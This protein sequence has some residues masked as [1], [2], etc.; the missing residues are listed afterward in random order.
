[1]Y[2]CI[3]IYIHAPETG[4]RLHGSA[5]TPQDALQ[6]LRP[7]CRGVKEDQDPRDSNTP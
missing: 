6:A 5:E 4:S 7:S 2:I 1:M 3:Y